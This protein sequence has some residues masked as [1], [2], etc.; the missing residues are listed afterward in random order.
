MF[1]AALVDD[2]AINQIISEQF[3]GVQVSREYVT[4]KFPETGIS[5]SV[6]TS[7]RALH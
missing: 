7:L 3:P 5:D 4:L 2:R 1:R 6:I